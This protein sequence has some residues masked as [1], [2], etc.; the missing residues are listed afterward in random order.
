[1]KTHIQKSP[2]HNRLIIALLNTVTLATALLFILKLLSSCNPDVPL[3]ETQIPSSAVFEEK[4]SAIAAISDIYARI[5]EEGVLSGNATSGTPLLANYGDD[6]VFYGTNVNTAQFANHTLLPSNTYVNTLWRT[7]YSHLYAINAFLEGM[8]ASVKITGEARERLVGE[9]LFLRAY[10]HFYLVNMYGEIPYVLSTDYNGNAIISKNTIDEVYSHIFA[11]LETAVTLVPASYA[12]EERVRPN[13]ATVTALLARVCL[14][15]GQWDRAAGYASQ[16]I[17]NPDYVW[18]DDIASEFLKDNTANIWMLHPGQPGFNSRDARSFVFTSGPPT[19][20]A[21][22]P[23]LVL[24]F[25]PGDLRRAN[26]VKTIN[27]AAGSWYHAN[28][29][30]R[31]ATT[32]TATEYTVLFRLAEMY[33]IRAEARAMQGDFNGARLD[34]NKIRSRAGLADSP[35]ADSGLVEAI[36]TE[37]RYELFTEQGHRFFDLKRTGT[38]NAILSIAK[39]NWQTHHIVLPLPENELLLNPR[40]LPQNTGY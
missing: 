22:S 18:Q 28:K 8:D 25:E 9:A 16:V 35:V 17:G 27:G 38:A 13:R 2:R 34:L 5:R 14:Y 36:L 6:M 32:G 19:R 30:K 3:P 4:S 31:T 12:T 24:G 1:M 21:L 26:W 20:P 7:T 29:Y 10:L 37:R 11:D 39:P 15:R 33:L 40:L 23:E